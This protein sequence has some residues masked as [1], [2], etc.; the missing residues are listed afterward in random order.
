M[1]R[2]EGELEEA[3]WGEAID[4]V[5]ERLR[6][7][8]GDAVGALG[9]AQATNEEAYLWGRFLR[10]VVGTP[11]IDAQLGDGIDPGCSSGST[12]GR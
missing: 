4:E 1:I 3:T 11:H 6:T 5:A 12:T 10:T 8:P 7:I 2:R 9:G